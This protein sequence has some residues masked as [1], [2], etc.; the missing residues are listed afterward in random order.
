VTEAIYELEM[1]RGVVPDRKLETGRDRRGGSAGRSSPPPRPHGGRRAQR[2][3][4]RRG[5]PSKPFRRGA[6]R[7]HPVAPEETLR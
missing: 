4:P 1:A 2:A 3:P 7:R 5:N 6:L